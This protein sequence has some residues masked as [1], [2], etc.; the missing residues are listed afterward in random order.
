M[1]LRPLFMRLRGLWWGKVGQSGLGFFGYFWVKMGQNPPLPSPLPSTPYFFLFLLL[2]YVLLLVVI[3]K[4]NQ[5]L[6]V[7][8]QGLMEFNYFLFFSIPFP[9]LIS[10]FFLIWPSNRLSE[11]R[12]FYEKSLVRPKIADIRII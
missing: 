6:L 1:A 7:G 9:I 8:N 3:G 10:F 4:N 2:L 11:K 5:F 12:I